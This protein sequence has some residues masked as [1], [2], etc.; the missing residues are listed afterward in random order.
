MAAAILAIVGVPSMALMLGGV[1]VSEVLRVYAFHLF[2]VIVPGLLLVQ[3]C[4][5]DRSRWWDRIALAWPLGFSVLL[6]LQLC[7]AH[8]AARSA[9]VPAL[10]LLTLGLLAVGP[11]R[12]GAIADVRE[13]ARRLARGGSPR[14][15]IWA[16]LVVVSV[17]SVAVWGEYYDR[18]PLPRDVET[19]QYYPDVPF[20]LALIE[21]AEREW[22]LTDPQ[23]SGEEFH[24][25]TFAHLAM[26]EE[27]RITGVP[28]DVVLLRTFPVFPLGACLV[29]LVALGHRLP[30]RTSVV[31]LVGFALVMLVG[32]IDLDPVAPSSF[33]NVFRSALLLSPTFTL[34]VPGFLAAVLCLVIAIESSA[35]SDRQI[36]LL[37][38]IALLVT[39]QPG[40][41][42]THLPTLIGGFAAVILVARV[43]GRF[44]VNA[45]GPTAKYT[46]AALVFSG[47]AFVVSYLLLYAGGDG[48]TLGV[49]PGG[50]VRGTL[51]AVPTQVPEPLFSLV[52]VALALLIIP[53]AFIPILLALAASVP[54]NWARR[55]SANWPTTVLTLCCGVFASGL[56][57]AVLLDHVGF[58]Q[59]YFLWPGYMLVA[60]VLASLVLMGLHGLKIPRPPV[61]AGVTVGVIAI[62][63]SV[64]LASAD[65]IG[66]ATELALYA[67]LLMAA[68]VSGVL[69]SSSN[70]ARAASVACVSCL[71]VVGVADGLL[72]AWGE[73]LVGNEV[74]VAVSAGETSGVSD[75][76][77]SVYR[78]IDRSF[79]E[80]TVFAHNVQNLDIGSV[81]FFYPAALTGR[82]AF[83]GGW[84]Y[85]DGAGEPRAF[86][87]RR[88]VNR[89]IYSQ[90]CRLVR[91]ALLESQVDLVIWDR[92]NDT[93][94][95]PNPI[96]R[97]AA[98]FENSDI[99]V[100]SASDLLNTCNGGQAM[101][102]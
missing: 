29:L 2:A 17:V 5:S 32:E 30:P 42:F 11:A 73:R 94:P 62:A 57:L 56:A 85:S 37:T 34:A 36:G 22:P 89:G 80:G 53:L 23:L 49:G 14:W 93:R 99:R 81:R 12:R 95:V 25:H 67:A 60:V 48:R 65:G 78:E 20:H 27:S 84:D 39:L 69:V 8:L 90:S 35:R 19:V 7:G 51:L 59:L 58:S 31:G 44:G 79:D 101:S 98:L 15:V 43:W 47:F 13:A 87:D 77:I 21:A 38:A 74:P 10:A 45:R 40:L 72:D 18:H 100:V 76:Q 61:A 50:F 66:R 88:Q 96:R 55:P 97:S 63:G 6:A 16:A 28:P 26:A 102:S 70:R 64:E 46:G 9:V 33:L 86:A 41:K 68:G 24:Y 52:S 71:V 4:V 83:L 92:L 54:H 1:S 82:S 75:A 3:L 91:P